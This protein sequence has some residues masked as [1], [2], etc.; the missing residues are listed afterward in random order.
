[1]TSN[2]PVRGLVDRGVLVFKGVR[3]GAPTGGSNRFLP[4][5]LPQPWTIIQDATSYGAS[6]VQGSMGPSIP[7]GQGSRMAEIFP[8]GG[9]QKATS[10]DCLFLNVWTPGLEDDGARPIM[11]WL[12]GG[13]FAIGS[14]ASPT[15]DGRPLASDGD[16]VVVTLNHRL[17]ALGYAQ[18]GALLGPE[19]ASSGEAGML[20]IVA[21]LKWVRDN[22]TTFGGDPGNVTIFGESGGGL[23]VSILLAMPAAK[24]LFHRAIIQSGPGLQMIERADAEELALALLD[25]LKI[26][27]DEPRKLLDVAPDELMAAAARASA[28]QV[29][30]RGGFAVLGGFQPVVDGVALPRHPFDPDAPAISI[31][32]PIVVGTTSTETTLFLMADPEFGK[33]SEASI[34]HRLQVMLGE[35]ADEAFALYRRL[36]PQADLTE[37]LARITTEAGWRAPSIKLAERKLAQQGAPVWMYQLDWNT[38]VLD[39]LL[40]APHAL[41]LPLVFNTTDETPGMVGSGPEP[42]VVAAQMS[43]TWLAFARHGDP[44][45]ASIPAWRPY[46]LDKRSVMFFDVV[47]HVENDP[48]ADGRAFWP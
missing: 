44:N 40:N 5:Q 24:G 26:N 12:H 28:K 43:A 21:A 3:Y 11:V 35:R 8:D 25:E 4:P 19:Y 46:S 22:A 6:A 48:A 42:K 7:T 10:E 23:K 45:N 17:G 39:G 9:A 13:G 34:R 27:S 41:D 33:F 37:L 47:S 32:I 20:D 18:L 30:P 38:P 16:V 15:Y 36:Y 31:D 1:M 14:G 29:A 2:G